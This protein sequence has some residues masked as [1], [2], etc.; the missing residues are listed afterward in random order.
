M[1]PSPLELRFYYLESLRWKVEADYDPEQPKPFEVADLQ[2]NL[3]R[4]D[5]ETDDPREA[6]Y[7][8]TLSLPTDNGRFP[9]SFEIILVGYFQLNPSV[10]DNQIERVLDCNAPA[11]LFGV[12]R[13]A[14]ATSLG[15][16]PFRPL[17]LPSVHFLGLQRENQAEE[18]SDKAATSKPSPRK[19]RSSK[20]KS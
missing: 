4:E 16:G 3:Q 2:W 12:A 18:P 5:N 8:L 1:L 14:L 20:Q 19:R 13:E 10:P 6:A 11:V 7:R 9:Y 15:R 17:V